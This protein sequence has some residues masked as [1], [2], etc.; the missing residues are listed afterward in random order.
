MEEDQQITK[1]TLEV[2][3]CGD[4]VGEDYYEVGYMYLELYAHFQNGMMNQIWEGST[5]DNNDAIAS[6]EMREEL[7]E[8]FLELGLDINE[9][10]DLSSSCVHDWEYPKWDQ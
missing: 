6:K 5:Y 4:D 9:V 1:I 2:G 3:G 8:A 7:K 10:I